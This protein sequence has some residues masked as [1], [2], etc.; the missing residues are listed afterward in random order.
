MQ[1]YMAEAR[2]DALVSGVRYG[3]VRRF[4]PG[5]YVSQFTLSPL[6]DRAEPILLL[7]P[8][9]SLADVEIDAQVGTEVDEFA[10]DLSG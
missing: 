4:L 5:R 6:H 8:Q 9:D 2:S 3:Q 7:G 1:K 10:L